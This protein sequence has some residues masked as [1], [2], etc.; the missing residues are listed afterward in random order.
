MG[1]VFLKIYTQIIRELLVLYCLHHMAPLTEATQVSIQRSTAKRRWFLPLNRLGLL[2]NDE[3]ATDVMNRYISAV[4]PLPL[5]KD[6]MDEFFLIISG[7]VGSL[8]AL[9]GVLGQASE[10]DYHRR[11][12]TQFDLDTISKTL[13]NHLKGCPFTRG[14]PRAEILQRPEIASIFKRAVACGEVSVDGL[15]KSTKVQTLEMIWRNG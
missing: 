4:G 1:R 9:M 11:H 12:G 14:L 8:R 15:K 13:F 6:L 7:H 10:L 5:S 2:L 3:E